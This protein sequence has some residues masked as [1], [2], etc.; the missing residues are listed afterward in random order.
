VLLAK[1]N[2]Q[3]VDT[4]SQDSFVVNLPLLLVFT[5]RRE[6]ASGSGLRQAGARIA[7]PS[8]LGLN[9]R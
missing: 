2:G 5:N 7:R 1:V 9:A 6:P 4:R 3:M 8:D